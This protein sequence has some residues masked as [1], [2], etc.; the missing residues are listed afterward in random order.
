MEGSLHN[1]DTEVA[2]FYHESTKHTEWSLRMNHHLLDFQNQPTPFKIYPTL[3]SVSLVRDFAP[4]ARPALSV[5]SR[6]GGLTLPTEE[7]RVPD[8][9]VLSRVLF[10]SAGIIK[11]KR[12]P[13][14][15][16]YFRAYPNTGALYHIDLYLVCGDIPGLSA[17]IYH[18]G[19]HD[20]ALRRL[21]Q[22]DYRE[23]LVEASGE[24]EHVARAPITLV[25]ASTYWR[26]AWKYQARAYRHCFWDA[27]TLHANLLAIAE[28]EGLGASVVT[29][30]V[31]RRVEQLL[32]LEPAREGALT[33]VPL[34]YTSQRPALAPAAMELELKVQSLSRTE[35]DYPA[36]GEMH[37]ASSLES[38]GQATAWRDVASKDELLAAP[39][40]CF[41][42]EPFRDEELPSEPLESVILRRGSTRYFDRKASISARQ[43]ATVLD[44][45]TRGVAA[46]FLGAGG[47]RID[48]Y[49][50]VHSVEGL[51]SGSYY[52]R[53]DECALELLQAGDHREVAGRLGL[54]QEL[55]ADAAVNVYCMTNLDSALARFG[56]RGYRAVQ[57]EAGILGG[58]IYLSAY[59][60]RFGATGLTFLDDEVT[61]F[62]SPH[63]EGKSAMFLTALGRSRKKS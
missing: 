19:P 63:A 24:E 18:F 31:D 6:G 57:L 49:L 41:P 38:A 40:R 43:L 42:L 7:E 62:F 39:G 51:P 11:R 46:D 53:R 22:G 45:T 28:A 61:Q 20:F 9:G 52:Y 10:Y 29:G 15:D 34:G 13:G 48:L 54:F 14:G 23:V 59:A 3:E 32:G 4:R 44:R 60:Q 58:R 26:N 12:Y 17:G 30:F 25:S 56:N 37:A 8:L 55:A 36:I 33:L 50:I 47:S 1:L 5:L 2:R 21:R 16:V 27:G 35:V